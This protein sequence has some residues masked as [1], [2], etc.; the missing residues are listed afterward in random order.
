[1][2]GAAEAH[3][4]LYLDTESMGLRLML[5]DLWEV[6]Y[7]FD[8]EPVDGTFLVHSTINYQDRALEVNR[9]QDKFDG[10][11]AEIVA[12][13]QNEAIL[14]ERLIESKRAGAKVTLV[15]ANPSFDAYRLS[16]RWG[17]EEPWFYRFLDVSVYAMPAMEATKPVALNNIAEWIA[18]TGPSDFPQPDH[19]ATQ[20]VHVVREVHRYLS[21]FYRQV[22]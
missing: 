3:D 18:E 12:L 22:F 7:A 16:R 17:W 20:D 15:G 5:D 19:T 1:M 8:D 21:E 4:F 10:T 9:Y 11:T 2:R 13:Q 14:R 6:A